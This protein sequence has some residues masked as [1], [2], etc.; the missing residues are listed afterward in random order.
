MTATSPAP[1]EYRIDELSQKTGV[2]TRSIRSYQVRKLLHP[3]EVRGR[4]G[5]YNETHVARIKVINELL[6]QGYT[7]THVAEFLEGW[8][9]GKSLPEVLRIEETL[10]PQLT[11]PERQIPV[12]DMVDL[13]GGA[14]DLVARLE[15]AGLLRRSE[16]GDFLEPRELTQLVESVRGLGFSD[17]ALVDLMVEIAAGAEAMSQAAIRRV[18]GDFEE[19]HGTGWVPKGEDLD[20]VG[21]LLESLRSN[22]TAF[23]QA[24]LMS[25]FEKALESAVLSYAETAFLTWT[26]SKHE[27]E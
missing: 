21:T 16:E 27:E 1:D 3:P 8:E 26:S 15:S 14:D 12:Q 20:R 4:V 5:F 25:A 18:V 23:A 9:K 22:G 11:A 13:F 17:V 7:S 24:T 6:E 19:Q 10:S 2:T